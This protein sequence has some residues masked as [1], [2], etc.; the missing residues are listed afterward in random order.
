MATYNT[1]VLAQR[2]KGDIKPGETFK[3]KTEK[4]IEE[5]QLEDGQFLV[6]V[7]YLSLDPAMRSWLN[8][9]MM[10][11]RAASQFRTTEHVP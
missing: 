9:T 10:L 5:S 1:V 6:E 2:P 7:H 8:G 4:K 3:I 11:S